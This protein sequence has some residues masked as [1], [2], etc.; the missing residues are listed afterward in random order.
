MKKI[1]AI[2]AILIGIGFITPAESSARDY[3]LNDRRIVRYHPCGTPIYAV[4]TVTKRDK[5]GRVIQRGWVTESANH[6]YCRA[7][8]PRSS[9]G[10]DHRRDDYRPGPP[11]RPSGGFFFG[12]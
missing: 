2:L 9:Y 11:R 10:H 7:C 4:Y 3:H 5:Y 8:Y 1:I 12:R 6:S